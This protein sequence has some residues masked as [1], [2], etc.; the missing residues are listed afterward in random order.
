MCI[1]DRDAAALEGMAILAASTAN[2]SWEYSLDGS[3]W[4]ALGNVSDTAAVLLAADAS[5]RIRFLPAANFNGLVDPAITFRAW[6]RT[7]GTN[8]DSTINL[9]VNGGISAYSSTTA[10]ASITVTPVNDPPTAVD[11]QLAVEKNSSDNALDVLANDS[12]APD[13]GETCLLY[14]SRCV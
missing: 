10:T 3:T 9:A 4:T 11:D 2:G 7:S 1:R 13:S 6:D 5:T 8:G 14:T 12:I